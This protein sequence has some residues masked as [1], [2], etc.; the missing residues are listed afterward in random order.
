MKGAARAFGFPFRPGWGGSWAGGIACLLL[1]PLAF[2]LLFGYVVGAVRSA[3]DDPAAGPPQWRLSAR[4]VTDGLWSSAQFVVLA[5]PF[6]VAA[7]AGSSLLMGR[8]SPAADPFLNRGLTLVIAGFLAAL[9]WGVVS[10]IV[11]PPSL[12]RFAASGRPADLADV[13]SAVRL[14]RSR[15]ADWNLAVVVIVTG[16]IVAVASGALL[17]GVIAGLFYA[18]LVSAHA[19]S[20]LA[21]GPPPRR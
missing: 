12:A 17:C 5:A 20:A 18:I 2:P 11:V 16:W 8:W 19:C 1:L 6:G 15:F 14:V 21:P 3:S 7:W 13:V 4:L 10:L 9:G